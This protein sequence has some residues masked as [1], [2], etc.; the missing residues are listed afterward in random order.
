M[1]ERGLLQV[2]GGNGVPVLQ[3]YV[4]ANGKAIALHSLSWELVEYWIPTAHLV[5]DGLDISLTYCAPPSSRAAVL[6]LAV[7]NRR[8]EPVPIALGVRAS[9]GK[10]SR[11]TYVPVDLNGTLTAGSAPWVESGE[12]FSYITDDT[13]FAWALLHPGSKGEL[14]TPPVS[15]S[16]AV[17][18]NR[19]AT[20]APGQTAESLFVLGVGVEEFS[21]AHNAR[22][23]EEI[24]DRD[25]FEKVL[26]QAAAWCRQRTRTSGKSDLD[27]LMNRN[28]LFTTLFA[29]GKTIDTEQTVGITSRSP[30]YYVSAA[31]WDRDAML[32][33]FPALLDTDPAM[34]EQALEYALGTQ[35][36][37]TGTHSRFIDGIVLED[38]FQLDEGVAPVIA[39]ASY[40]KKTGDTP[41]LEQHRAAVVYL[42]DRI[43]SRYDQSTGL[44]SSL[45]DSQDEYQ[46]LPFLTYDNALT[47]R[48]LL[49]LSD[50]FSRLNDTQTAQDL[51]H[52]ADELHAAILAHCVSAAAPGADGPIF[53]SATDGR[54][55]VFTE[56]PPGSLMKLATLGFVPET[57]PV[58]AR[59]YRWLHSANYKYS[60]TDQPY[61]LPGSYRLPFT[62]SWSVAD[63]LLLHAG[64]AQALKILRAS[65]WDGGIITEG[66]DPA[67]ARMDQAGRAF[68]TAAGYVADAI[69]QAECTDKKD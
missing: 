43:L 56:I 24:L 37:N 42:R 47:W 12:V 26:D 68:A 66:V 67:S 49:G 36:R 22:A 16:A 1:R 39:L 30:R 61:G 8:S 53:A 34:A 27:L 63:H 35:L 20:L 48:A 4:Q 17:D 5:T 57:D 7:T 38:G 21:A 3:P 10:L 65:Q 25:G 58:F 40:A 62:T 55:F 23:L 59:T 60:Y 51:K 64:H 54:N 31:Y 14:T 6:R 32:W 33:S 29:W 28:F 69:C 41:F 9:W 46:K 44:F 13:R 45:Q 19:T 15:R 50:I 52:R 2:S 18:A 11:V